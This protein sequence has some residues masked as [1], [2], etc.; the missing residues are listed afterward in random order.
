MS[1]R[2]LVDD[3]SC[4]SICRSVFVLGGIVHKV[5]VGLCATLIRH[6]SVV[7]P[8]IFEMSLMCGIL[9]L[10]VV[11]FVEMPS[12]SDFDKLSITKVYFFGLCYTDEVLIKNWHF[13][14]E[15]HID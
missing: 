13:T 15:C 7:L 3:T 5:A 4:F 10:L 14:F 8:E 9:I 1:A 6:G 11:V 2:R 12:T